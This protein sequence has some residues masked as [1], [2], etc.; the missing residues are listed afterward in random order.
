MKNT[1]L[2]L[3]L[4]CWA[5]SALADNTVTANFHGQ[6]YET[7]CEVAPGWINQVIDLSGA[8]GKDLIYNA[9]LERKGNASSWVLF[10]LRVKNCPSVTKKVT[11]TFTGPPDGVYFASSGDAKNVAIELQTTS[12]EVI[13]NG[14]R[15]TVNVDTTAHTAMLNLQTRAVSK[16]ATTP[17]SME[18]VIQVVFNYE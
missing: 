5:H 13:S 1:L 14:T 16:G 8:T 4:F 12:G 2:I 11:A 9:D 3:P 18:T 7:A 6:I 10:D 17:G 15:K